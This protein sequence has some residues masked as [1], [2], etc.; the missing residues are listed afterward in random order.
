VALPQDVGDIPVYG[1]DGIALRCEFLKPDDTG[2]DLSASLWTLHMRDD[3][4]GEVDTTEAANGVVYIRVT[5]DTVAQMKPAATFD[6]HE[7]GQWGRTLIHG[8]FKVEA[9]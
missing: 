1:R 2:Y 9:P 6:L 3:L 5:A 7:D 8:R 4:P